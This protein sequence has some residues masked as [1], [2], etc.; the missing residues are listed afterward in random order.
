[1][2]HEIKYKAETWFT[3]R[4]ELFK[5]SG[6]FIRTTCEG[7]LHLVPLT[8]KGELT[9]CDIVIDKSILPELLQKLADHENCI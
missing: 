5:S 7:H 2:I 3:G 1:M 6:I 9:H 4:N 8:S